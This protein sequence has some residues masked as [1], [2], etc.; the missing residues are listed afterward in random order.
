MWTV[1][2]SVS[3]SV[4]Y[5]CVCVFAP[6]LPRPADC[7]SEHSRHDAPENLPLLPTESVPGGLLEEPQDQG[8]PAAVRRPPRQRCRG[9]LQV[10]QRP[11]CR[12]GKEL[13]VFYT[14]TDL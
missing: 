2:R 4:I 6:Q 9:L 8:R 14:F 3:R 10:L 7:A 11:H 1:S 13:H 12:Y 5:M